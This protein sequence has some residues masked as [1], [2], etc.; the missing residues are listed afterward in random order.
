MSDGW[1]SPSGDPQQA[2]QPQ[3]GPS[4]GGQGE[5]H[6]DRP[7]PRYGAYGPMPPQQGPPQYGGPQYGQSQYGQFQGGGPYYNG[8]NQFRPMAPKPGVVP[9]RPL[10]LGDIFGGAFATIRGN[11]AATLGLSLIVHLIVAVPSLILTLWLKDAAFPNGI[12]FNP[13][14]TSGGGMSSSIDLNAASLIAQVFSYIGGIVLAGMLVVVVSEAVLGRRITMG[15]TWARIRP[16][17]WA[18]LGMTVLLLLGALL[19]IA[20]V[21]GIIVLVAATAGTALAVVLGIVLGLIL[22]VALI[23][24]YTRIVLASPALVLE[25]IGPIAAIRRSW[26]LTRGAFW[27]VLGISLLAALVAGFVGGFANLP[28]T[29]LTLGGLSTSGVTSILLLVAAQLWSAVVTAV[30]APFVTG[31]TGLLYIDQRMRREGLDV[32]LM[33]AAAQDGHGRN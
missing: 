23:A 22:L 3:Q 32:A 31:T 19:A 9:L 2:Q 11:P 20:V 12:N 6:D 24:V 15:G 8:P 4:Y 33:S 29:F 18:L 16:R 7:P 28:A 27:R 25:G 13:D 26:G 17:I 14:T 30:V 10:S 1:A 21:V 5:H